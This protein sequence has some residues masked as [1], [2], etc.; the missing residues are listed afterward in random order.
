M[1]PRLFGTAVA[2]VAA[3][4][5]VTCKDDP[6]A[7]LAGGATRLLISP[8]PVFLSE[9]ATGTFTVQ[10]V[11]DALRGIATTYDAT[12]G[13]PSIATVAVD[14]LNP[15]PS[16]TT[17]RFNLAGLASGQA[18]IS[19]TGAGLTSEDT[20]NV[21]PLEFGGA[22]STTSPNVGQP[23]TLYATSVLKFSPTSQLVFGERDAGG[24]TVDNNGL[25][26]NLHPE[27][28]TVIVPQP[29]EAQPRA[30]TVGNV[31]VTFA[32][33]ALFNLA[34]A[35]QFDVVNPYEPNDAPD[36]AAIVGAGTFYDGFK[37]SQVDK[38]YRI[39]IPAG[40]ANV[41]FLLEWSGPADVDILLCDAGCNNFIGN[42][43]GATGN[44]PEEATMDLPAG[45]H[46]LWINLYDAADEVPHLYKMT[47]TFN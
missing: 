20:V 36:P 43:S 5:V 23:F 46:N 45:T 42:F 16:G 14:T 37:G 22:G 29:E 6:T 27:S 7:G 47:I 13:D 41:T 2:L 25:I 39:T 15:D 24:N 44:N 12:S 30:L 32:P 9:G 31:A 11:N 34:T 38:F 40:G 1:K 28:L 18:L 26:V 21:L 19:V 8:N 17:Q 3:L 10:A 35:D 4:A 33:G